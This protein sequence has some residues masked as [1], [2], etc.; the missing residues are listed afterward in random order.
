MAN[1]LGLRAASVTLAVAVA[2]AAA[3]AAPIPA[4]TATT[5]IPAAAAPTAPL[6]GPIAAFAIDWTVSAWLK[7]YRRG[8]S[9]AGA[10]HGCT[11]TRASA[12]A[13]AVTALRL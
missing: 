1:I 4:T 5:A 9:A 6:F 7:G 12:R 10:D 13:G 2:A 3:T 8:L 11:R